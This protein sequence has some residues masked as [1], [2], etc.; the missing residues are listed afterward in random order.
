MCKSW[1]A[2]KYSVYE[3]NR[4]FAKRWLKQP[5]E[6]QSVWHSVKKTTS[7]C[8]EM[9]VIHHLICHNS[10]IHSRAVL[11]NLDYCVTG[12]SEC[13][14]MILSTVMYNNRLRLKGHSTASSSDSR[15]MLLSPTIWWLWWL[16]VCL[17]T[18][19]MTTESRDVVAYLTFSWT[20]SLIINIED[21]TTELVSVVT[22][23]FINRWC[24]VSRL[25]VCSSL[26]VDDAVMKR[27]CNSFSH[28]WNE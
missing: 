26:D 18:P 17:N 7:S 1:R 24:F 27:G 10:W 28:F 8:L 21:I 3:V 6:S 19:E 12:H 22:C 4:A 13:K 5:C 9:S 14:M 20:L 25:S 2:V 11:S 23:W 15:N 16:C